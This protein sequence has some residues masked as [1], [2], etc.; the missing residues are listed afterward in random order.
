MAYDIGAKIALEGEASF[1]QALRGVNSQLKALSS[2]MKTAMSGFDAADRSEQKLTK[3]NDVL[4]RSIRA[5][6]DKVEILT[7]QYNKQKSELETLEKALNKANEEFGE[8]SKEAAKAQNAYNKQVEVVNRLATNLNDATAELNQMNQELSEN[9]RELKKSSDQL[10]KFSEKMSEAGGKMK[11]VGSSISGVGKK[12]TTCI[13]V[14]LVGIGTASVKTTADFDS[15]MSE[16]AAISGA[17]G[18]EFVALREKA[19]E[20]G[21]KT[22][23]SAS[24]SAEAMK[25]MAMAGWDSQQ[26]LDGLAGIMNAAAASGEELGSVSDI[27]TDGLTAFGMAAS[28]SGRMADVLTAAATS[29]NT[30]IGLLGETFKYTAPVCGSLG[31]NLEDCAV[32]TGLMAN[33]G[34]KGSEAG[35]ALRAGLV[36]LIKPSSTI[37]AAMEKY[38]ISMQTNADG[39][40]NLSATMQLLRDRMGDMTETERAAA[41]AAIFGKEAVSGWSAIVSASESDFNKL[42]NAIANSNGA[43]E[44]IANIKLD[45]LSGQITILKSTLEG[46]AIQIGDILTPSVSAAVSKIQE[47]ATSF[48]NLDEGVKRTIV[49]IAGIAVAVGPVVAAVGGIISAIGGAVTAVGGLAAAISAGTGVIGAAGAAIGA[50]AG[51]IGLLVVGVAA[52][53]IAIVTHWDDIKNAAGAF[54]D[55]VANAVNQVKTSW[56]GFKES[57]AQVFKRIAND[58]GTMKSNVIEKAGEL[59]NGA[60]NAFT[61]LATGAYTK[62]N[63]M[64]NKAFSV[65]GTMLSGIK[66]KFDSIKSAI[67]SKINAAKDAVSSAI[68]KI[69]NAFNFKWSLP[70]LKLPHISVT[71][72]KAPFGIGGKGSLPKFSIAWYAKGGILTSPTIFGMNGNSLLGG[73]E[74]GAEAVIPLSELWKQME[75]KMS[76]FADKIIT[77]MNEMYANTIDEERLARLIGQ[78]IAKHSGSNNVTN[79]YFANGASGGKSRKELWRQ[80]KRMGL[81]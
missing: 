48:S 75:E 58:F 49:T 81:V 16:V 3:R 11:S 29:S 19:I 26:M 18:E 56:E 67:T 36:N 13:S 15:A 51:P 74:A 69:K 4:Q 62:F 37:A 46:I 14:P 66:S 31:I 73:G 25:Y 63:M 79:N 5:A 1:R 77:H 10:T 59:K 27:L 68:S 45:N 57:Q 38:G 8:N 78:E 35:T 30:T 17:T 44:D 9:E 70:K 28:D 2:E 76:A 55:G 65:I 54:K 52:A 21:S 47:I 72:G 34:I 80:K 64:K 12:L 71:G 39:S 60:V 6:G 41:L 42:T 24:E 61:Q 33:A 40:A 22:K 20:M 7:K 50:L 53:A 23:F 43:A 32:A